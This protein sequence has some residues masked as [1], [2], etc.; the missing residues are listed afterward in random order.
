M[1]NGYLIVLPIFNHSGT[2]TRLVNDNIFMKHL[3]DD[4][5]AKVILPP[6]TQSWNCLA[7]QGL[8]VS[9]GLADMVVDEICRIAQQPTLSITDH[10]SYANLRAD[11]LYERMLG[12]PD[13]YEIQANTKYPVPEMLMGVSVFFVYYF[14]N[15]VKNRTL[16]LLLI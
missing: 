7:V 4:F 12:R 14:S 3:A 9:E 5:Q 11:I 6:R 10:Y 13:L 8:T 1:S 16:S 2:F 15:M